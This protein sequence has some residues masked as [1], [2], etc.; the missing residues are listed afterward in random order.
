MSVTVTPLTSEWGED[1]M[2]NP[3]LLSHG[4]LMVG[5]SANY[6]Y[7][8]P[9]DTDAGPYA[10][11]LKIARGDFTQVSETALS[12]L[13]SSS[14]AGREQDLLHDLRMPALFYTVEGTHIDRLFGESLHKP[15]QCH[16]AIEQYRMEVA[17]VS[18][19]AKQFY[20]EKVVKI[21]KLSRFQ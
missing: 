1:R 2:L 16:D 4:I 14:S 13:T 17:S 8:E 7:M 19:L 9:A 11:F 15:T 5:D 12:G 3:A 6:N 21:F 10:R 20:F 18:I